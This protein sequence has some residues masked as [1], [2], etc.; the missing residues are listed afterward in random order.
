MGLSSLESA[1]IQLALERL[2][3]S[4]RQSRYF[5]LLISI[6]TLE[7]DLLSQSIPCGTKWTLVYLFSLIEQ[8]NTLIEQSN[9]L[10]EQS[11]T[12]IEQSNT[13]IE[14]SNTLIEQSCIKAK[15]SQK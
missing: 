10:I 5:L 3:E 13:L 2:Q 4:A 1:A 11:N 7:S 6:G 12:L 9:T 14:Q 15:L 8:S